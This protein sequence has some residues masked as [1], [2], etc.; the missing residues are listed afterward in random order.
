MIVSDTPGFQPGDR[1]I[2]ALCPACAAQLVPEKK[3]TSKLLNVEQGRSLVFGGFASFTLVEET[4]R[5]FLAY[6]AERVA[7]HLTEERKAGELLQTKPAWLLPWAC[8][9]CRKAGPLRREEIRLEEYEDL[10]VSGL[11]WISLRGG[12]ATIRAVLPE[13]IKLVRQEDYGRAA[14][15][16]L[17][18][19]L[20]SLIPPAVIP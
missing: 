20:H 14:K 1:L 15:A 6:A 13:G 5:V 2:D 10:A 12:A 17:T 4:P 9:A 18:R 8:A 16:K 3:L 11:G 19:K 7:L